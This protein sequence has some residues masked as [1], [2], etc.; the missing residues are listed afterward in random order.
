MKE[1]EERYIEL[2]K[3]IAEK[4]LKHQENNERAFRL[5]EIQRLQSELDS[6]EREFRASIGEEQAEIE[7]IEEIFRDA[8]DGERKTVDL[9]LLTLK[10]RVTKSIIPLD[11]ISIVETLFKND[12]V[13]E[14]VATFKKPFLRKLAE[15]GVLPEDSYRWN[16]K[17]SMTVQLPS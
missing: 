10:F 12:K 1:Y 5:L 16:E 2:R 3:L 14:G 7:N 9:D 6:I 17:V 4:H 13:N 15:V 8:Y 11:K